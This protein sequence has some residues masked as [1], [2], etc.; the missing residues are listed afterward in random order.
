VRRI[1]FSILCLVCA[2]CMTM[3]EDPQVIQHSRELEL[4][5]MSG[6]SRRFISLRQVQVGMTQ[7]EVQSI[8]GNKVMIGYKLKDE[9]SRHYQPVTVP[10]P[11]RSETYVVGSKQ[12]IADFY[13]AGISEPDSQVSDDELIPIVFL[14][15]QLVG[16]GWM[17]LNKIA[18]PLQQ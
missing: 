17:F 4:A 15:D 2:G 10:N 9:E 6:M 3:G 1:F 12:Y 14:D 5:K 11:H 8:L 13:L 16:T 7:K 18:G